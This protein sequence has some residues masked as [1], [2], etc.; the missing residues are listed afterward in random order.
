MS[1]GICTD[2]GEWTDLDKPCCS[3]GVWMEGAIYY[4][5]SDCD[6]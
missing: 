3:T 5:D 4:P 6:D 2:C 1:L